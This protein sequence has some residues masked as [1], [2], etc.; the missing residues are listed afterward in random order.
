M[1]DQ[2]WQD[3]NLAAT[4]SSGSVPTV[5][6]IVALF[7]ASG[8]VSAGIA[9]WVV[10]RSAHCHLKEGRRVVLCVHEAPWSY[11]CPKYGFVFGSGWN[12]YANFPTVPLQEG[13]CLMKFQ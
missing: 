8:K 11:Y 2:V 7:A 1:A 6:M 12:H 10:S 4:V 5:G 9:E 3:G 13:R